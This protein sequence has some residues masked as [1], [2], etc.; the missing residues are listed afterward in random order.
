LAE[1]GF[2]A[3]VLVHGLDKVPAEFVEGQ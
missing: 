1:R 2:N 3:S